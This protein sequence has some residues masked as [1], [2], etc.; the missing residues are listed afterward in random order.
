[1][2]AAT[3]IPLWL[4][5]GLPGSGKSSWAGHFRQVAPAIAY[6]STDQ[7]RGEL[8]GNEAIQGPWPQVWGRVQQEF[9]AAVQQTH[10]GRLSGALYDATNVQRRGR[11]RVIQTAQ[12]LGFTRLLAVWFDLPLAECLQRNQGRSRQVPPDIIETMSRQ[13]SGA[14]P[15]PAEGFAAV[16]RLGGL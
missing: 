15:H 4:L 7:I 11:R 14:P 6:I 13:L 1:M 9:Q 3:D 8:F 2:S 16:Y 10:E 12:S 5:I